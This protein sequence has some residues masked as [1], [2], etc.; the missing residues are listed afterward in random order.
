MRTGAWPS[1]EIIQFRGRINGALRTV[2]YQRSDW[3]LTIERGRPYGIILWDS[4]E[5]ADAAV[6]ALSAYLKTTDPTPDD[7][8]AWTRADGSACSF[9]PLD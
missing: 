5:R 8:E 3:H 7:P 2:G 1:N 6:D 4:P 9:I